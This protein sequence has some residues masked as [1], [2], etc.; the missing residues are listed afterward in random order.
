[1]ALVDSLLKLMSAQGADVLVIPS[2]EPPWL[3]KR[4]E[5]RPLSMPAL[6]RDM[7]QAMVEEL[8]AAPLRERLGRGES[9]ESQYTAA[10]GQL[11]MVL[12][13]PRAAGPRLTLRRAT[14][15]DPARSSTGGQ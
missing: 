4:G 11:H 3:A 12:V 9:V 2:T 1:M 6:G 15:E 8:V 14:A 10:D 5:P 7:V 13:E